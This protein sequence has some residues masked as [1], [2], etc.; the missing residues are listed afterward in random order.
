MARDAFRPRT[1]EFFTVG[2][3][4][5]LI[6]VNVSFDEGRDIYDATRWAWKIDAER[7][8]QRS[9]VLAHNRGLVVAA[10]GAEK[11]VPATTDNFP[12]HPGLPGRWGFIG[13]PAE[14]EVW[15]QYVG[16]RVPDEYRTKGA[17]NPT[18]YCP[19]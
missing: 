12:G 14:D 8:G 18:R 15:Q 11:W 5:I 4:L 19:T 16:K 9:L 13:R 3:P 7:A 2:E 10:Y 6:C 17:A 1:A